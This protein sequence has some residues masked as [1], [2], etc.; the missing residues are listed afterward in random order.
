[1]KERNMLN[2][3]V[4]QAK[5]EAQDHYFIHK[6]GDVFGGHKKP[7]DCYIVFKGLHF[8][9][10]A[11]LGNAELTANQKKSLN[12]IYNIGGLSFV[13]R[14]QENKDII[15]IPFANGQEGD[16]SYTLRWQ[17]GKLGYRYILDLPQNLYNIWVTRNFK[18]GIN[19]LLNPLSI[20]N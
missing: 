2:I 10:E 6:D 12:W 4:R 18:N 7:Y 3:M 14:I 5:R 1:M 13:G 15:F 19:A 20:L 11:K 17:G 8:A 16:A 9:I